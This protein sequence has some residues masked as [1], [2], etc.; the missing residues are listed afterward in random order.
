MIPLGPAF[1]LLLLFFGVLVS[2]VASVHFLLVF[3]S[4]IDCFRGLLK[5]C[6]GTSTASASIFGAI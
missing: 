1:D 4:V 3:G 6:M 5:E 2:L